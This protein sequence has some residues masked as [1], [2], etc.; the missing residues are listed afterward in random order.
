MP[1]CSSH[2]FKGYRYLV[3]GFRMFLKLKILRF[4]L[5]LKLRLCSLLLKKLKPIKIENDC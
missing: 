2:D 1:F 5:V 3:P 4:E